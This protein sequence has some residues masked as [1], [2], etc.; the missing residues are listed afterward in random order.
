[1]ILQ[2]YIA[3]SLVRG[4]LMVLLVI[5]SVF[6]LIGFITELERT[7][8]DLII[9]DVCMPELGGFGLFS[10]LR[11]GDGLLLFQGGK[12]GLFRHNWSDQL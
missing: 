8:F 5:G 12:G 4:W 3:G 7:R 11:F 10:K 1:M 6:G 9:A 2:R